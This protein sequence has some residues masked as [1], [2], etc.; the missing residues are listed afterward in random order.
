MRTMVMAKS[1]NKTLRKLLVAILEADGWRVVCGANGVLSNKHDFLRTLLEA[2]NGSGKA[3]GG[4][5]V[6]ERQSRVDNYRT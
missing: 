3:P 1:S 6:C 4:R 5:S 2:S